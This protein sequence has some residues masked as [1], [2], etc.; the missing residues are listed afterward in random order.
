MEFGLNHGALA[1]FVLSAAGSCSVHPSALLDQDGTVS[2]SVF[3]WIREHRTQH[4]NHA[5]PPHN[6]GAR[7]EV[8]STQINAHNNRVDTRMQ[9]YT[10]GKALAQSHSWGMTPPDLPLHRLRPHQ[11]RT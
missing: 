10:A 8:H 6:R 2:G 3:N 9:T 11:T 1:R 7:G 5:T 4:A